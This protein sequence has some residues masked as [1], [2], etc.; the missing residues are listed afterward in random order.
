MHPARQV[1]AGLDEA[2]MQRAARVEELLLLD[3]HR[4]EQPLPLRMPPIGTPK[5]SVNSGD[6][7]WGTGRGQGLRYVMWCCSADL[8]LVGRQLLEA[9]LVRL[10]L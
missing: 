3:A 8:E 9:Q 4:R 6:G 2:Q 5:F 10:P 1:Y 7:G